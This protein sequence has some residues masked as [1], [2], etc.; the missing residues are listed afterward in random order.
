MP[1]TDEVLM[2]PPV[3]E[4]YSDVVMD[5]PDLIEIA[6]NKKKRTLKPLVLFKTDLDSLETEMIK[7]FGTDSLHQVVHWRQGRDESQEDQSMQGK[8][9]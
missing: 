3:K 5:Y 4:I 2:F 1:D 8:G 9:Q 7:T 6:K